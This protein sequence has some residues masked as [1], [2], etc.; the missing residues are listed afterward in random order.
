MMLFVVLA[1]V[2]LILPLEMGTVA[3]YATR[4]CSPSSCCRN[5]HCRWLD[6]VPPRCCCWRRCWCAEVPGQSRMRIERYR[7]LKVGC[8]RKW[9]EKEEVVLYF[10]EISR[11]MESCGGG[12]E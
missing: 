11:W 6:V 2:L 7:K 3:A 12:R 4:C 8:R 5:C 1:L 10:E 9:V